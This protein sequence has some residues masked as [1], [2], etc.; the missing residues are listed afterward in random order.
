MSS[1]DTDDYSSDD[2]ECPTCGKDDF[3]D[4]SRM[5]CHHTRVHGESLA[6]FDHECDW[7]GETFHDKSS[8]AKYCSRDCYANAHGPKVS[9]ENNGNWVGGEVELTC[10]YCGDTYHRPPAKSN[11]PYCSQECAG[12]ATAHEP[13]ENPFYQG[14]KKITISCKQCGTAFE[15]WEHANRV[16]CSTT[17]FD[18]WQIGWRTGEDAPNWK[19]GKAPYGEG[20]NRRKKRKVRIRDQARCQHCGRTEPEHLEKY[21][22]KQ[23]VHH[24]QKARDFDDPEKRNA[25]GNLVTLCKGECHAKWE[26]MSPLRP[27]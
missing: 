16:F 7:C 3:T 9:G 27:V 17:C 8:K 6:G 22:C 12:K 18:E 11:R 19:G 21:G 20:W 25:M 14:G 26:K 24:I 23:E 15:A 10:D 5:K 1:D 13:E 2:V 4:R